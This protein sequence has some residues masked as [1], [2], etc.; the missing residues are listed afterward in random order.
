MKVGDLVR[1][2]KDFAIPNQPWG[3]VVELRPSSICAFVGVC[4]LSHIIWH[5]VNTLEIVSESR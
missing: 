2:R 3:V 4:W 1:R 5:D